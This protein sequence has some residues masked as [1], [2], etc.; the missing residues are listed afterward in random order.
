MIRPTL[1]LALLA[2]AAACAPGA[3]AKTL[4]VGQ[5]K[6]YAQPSAAIAAASPGDT[7]EIYPGQYFDCAVVDKDRLTITGV[8]DGAVMTDKT[9]QGKA[10]LVI[11]AS[12][13]TVRNLT[14][15]R[16]RVPDRNGAGIRAEGPD[17]TVDRVS[18]VNN[19]NGILAGENPGSTIRVLNSVFDRNGVCAAACAHGIYVGPIKLLVVQN[20]RFTNTREGHHIKSRAARTEISGTTIM[21]GPEG[22]S[23]YLVDIPNGGALVMTGDTLEKGP[24]TQNHSTAIAVGEE[25]VTQPTPEI[26][27]RNSSFTNDYGG[28]TTLLRNLTATEAQISNTRLSGNKTVPLDGDGS[29]S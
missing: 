15:T 23:S 2:V 3:S 7:V 13:V 27:V 5:G 18:F 28:Q 10:I 26:T 1:C 29:A 6:A 20:S 24:K 19:E 8:G 22:T 12:G 17:L 25:G 21:D 14:L 4:M 16:A 11:T 9:C